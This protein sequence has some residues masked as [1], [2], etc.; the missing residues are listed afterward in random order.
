MK[1][2]PAIMALVLSAGSA[3]AASEV[4]CAQIEYLLWS[5]D[6]VEEEASGSDRVNKMKVTRLSMDAMQALGSSQAFA[7]EGALPAEITEAL[8]TIRDSLRGNEDA[9]AMPIEEARPRILESGIAIVAA[10]P[11]PCPDADLPDLAAYL[12]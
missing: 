1:I 6:E 11:G 7:D 5:I 10:M 8:E 3:S 12:D 2:I 9:P 4:V